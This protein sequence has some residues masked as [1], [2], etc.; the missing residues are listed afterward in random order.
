L[1]H[2]AQE[3]N[4]VQFPELDYSNYRLNISQDVIMARLK[5]KHKLNI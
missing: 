1:A 3:Q 4:L 2:R 5:F